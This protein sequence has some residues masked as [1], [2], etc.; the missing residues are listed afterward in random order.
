MVHVSERMEKRVWP[1]PFSLKKEN[2]GGLRELI[3]KVVRGAIK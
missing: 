1:D 3:N 2:P